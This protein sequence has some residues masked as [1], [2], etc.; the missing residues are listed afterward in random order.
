MLKFF[1]VNNPSG[2]FPLKLLPDKSK[3]SIASISP[4]LSEVGPKYECPQLLQPSYGSWDIAT[5]V[6]T[7]EVKTPELNQSIDVA[8]KCSD[9]VVI[10]EV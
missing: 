1:N 7:A 5:E 10:G 6:I 3:Y 2:I 4:I 8:R 9:K